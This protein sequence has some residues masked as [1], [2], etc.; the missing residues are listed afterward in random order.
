[1]PKSKKKSPLRGIHQLT[2]GVLN[3][4]NLKI[5]PI[6][7][8]IK[9]N[10][11]AEENIVVGTITKFINDDN[12][13]KG[14]LLQIPAFHLEAQVFPKNDSEDFRVSVPENYETKEQEAKTFW[15]DIGTISEQDGAYYLALPAY[16]RV[17][18]LNTI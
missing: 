4:I 6:M 2:I 13:T 9:T 18:G 14:R 12:S 17:F 10:V 16:N 3:Q 5:S 15:H 8:T 7:K 1:V 11:T